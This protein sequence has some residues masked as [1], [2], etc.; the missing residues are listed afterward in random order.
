MEKNKIIKSQMDKIKI[1]LDNINT[2]YD[3]ARQVLY[4]A[5]RKA[6]KDLDEVVKQKTSILKADKLEL[7]R[8]YKEI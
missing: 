6:L 7:S 2:Q 8:Q 4:E 5:L 1:S 3:K